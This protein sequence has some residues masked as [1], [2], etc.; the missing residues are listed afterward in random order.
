MIINNFKYNNLLNIYIYFNYYSITIKIFFVNK[1]LQKN[2]LKKFMY[3]NAC[4]YNNYKNY[5]NL[6]YNLLII[7]ILL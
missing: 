4:N 6:H 7:L 2:L 1:S 5:F 3:N